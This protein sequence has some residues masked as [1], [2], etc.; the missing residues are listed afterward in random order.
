MRVAH[1]DCFSGISGDMVLG[2]F[3][4][5]GLPASTLRRELKKLPL[6]GYTIGVEK[7]SRNHMSGTQVRI[8][9][10]KSAK[11]PHRHLGHIVEL[12]NGS[13][14]LERVKADA[15]GIFTRL[16]EAEAAVHGVSIE[17]V[18][19]HEV[20][21]VD[22]ILDIVGAAVA[23][24]QLGI[25]RVTSS[26]LALG[27]GTVK[28]A[29]GEIP[30]PVPATM[31]LL[32]G[33]PV[34]QSGIMQEM[35]T[36]TGAAIVTHYASS[37]AGVPAMTVRSVGYG[38]GTRTIE[39]RPNLLRVVIGDAEETAL[40]EAMDVIETNIDDM[41]PEL[42]GAAFE[43]LFEA[44]ALD[45][46]ITPLVMKKN[47]PGHLVTVL[48]D[49]AKTAALIELMLTETTTFGVRTYHTQKHCL[50]RESKTVKT[51]YGPVDVK[52][53]LLGGRPVKAAPEYE[54]CRKA[55]KAKSI[56]LRTVFAAAEAAA[57][58]LLKQPKVK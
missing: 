29:H 54:S 11:Q 35:V 36:P 50:A 12:I 37:F 48:C 38:A 53:G 5:A 14:L 46:Y 27:S 31:K 20:G 42:L 15:T 16:G 8:R 22:S 21:A 26:P 30:V 4:D 32:Q 23:I 57:Q 47:R 24:E 18:H 44:G 56:P 6:A 40:A 7:V 55:A 28:I 13:G 19:F 10:A 45:A 49:P 43:R 25:E 1:F 39:G 52:V 58:S 3:V 2:A 17:K 34:Y 9:V 41:T 33:V 51:A